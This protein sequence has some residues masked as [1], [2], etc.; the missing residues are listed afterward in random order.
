MNV[1]LIIREH[2]LVIKSL[3]R[4]EVHVELLHQADK[5]NTELL[6]L[7]TLGI[8]LSGGNELVEESSSFLGSHIIP[9]VDISPFHTAIP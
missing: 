6:K 4:L 1:P 2:L 9:I 8:H 5:T 7:S 3:R